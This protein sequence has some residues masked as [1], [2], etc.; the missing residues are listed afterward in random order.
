MDKEARAYLAYLARLLMVGLPPG[1]PE[2][3]QNHLGIY[4]LGVC[5]LT[6]LLHPI[7]G[8]TGASLCPKP[9]EAQRNSRARL[10]GW[11]LRVMGR[12]VGMCEGLPSVIQGHGLAVVLLHRCHPHSLL[13]R[14]CF[15]IRLGSSI[16]HIQWA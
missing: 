9:P 11:Q 6:V 14:C 13:S 15:N 2:S 3:G 10:W 8:A 4:I 16:N 12:M 5:F 1:R 7:K